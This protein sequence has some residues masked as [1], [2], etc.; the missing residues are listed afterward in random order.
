MTRWAGRYGY[1]PPVSDGRW[2]TAFPP[3]R[4]VASHV[5]QQA[6]PASFN[7]GAVAVAVRR[8]TR[9]ASAEQGNGKQVF[10]MRRRDACKAG[11]GSGDAHAGSKF[12][13]A[14][15]RLS[16]LG[17]LAG[18][19]SRKAGKIQWV[20]APRILV[21][22][23]DCITVMKMVAGSQLLCV[24]PHPALLHGSELSSLTPLPIREGLP[25]Y[26]VSLFW[27]APVWSCKQPA[28]NGIIQA[29]KN[30]QP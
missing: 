26:E 2:Q 18:F 17:W 19:A 29:L 27:A 21:E 15:H 12:F 28:L 5:E 7:Q 23:P 25:R 13:Q 24:I 8:G 11:K 16:P 10:G 22:C 6:L 30:I 14:V 3:V 1:R 20:D 4:E 9:R